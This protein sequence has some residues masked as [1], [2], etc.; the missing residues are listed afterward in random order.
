MT[1]YD[2]SHGSSSSCTFATAASNTIAANYNE[3]PTAIEW[4][5]QTVAIR[6]LLIRPFFES[7][8]EVSMNFLLKKAD[9]T[10]NS[11]SPRPVL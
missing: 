4:G 8:K 10:H 5:T 2:V 7:V 11:I 1:P 3:E 9:L 6:D